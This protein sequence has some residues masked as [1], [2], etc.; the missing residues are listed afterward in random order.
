MDA[1]EAAENPPRS[2]AYERPHV[3]RVSQQR[4]RRVFRRLLENA[5]ETPSKGFAL[6]RGCAV[7]NR[8][9]FSTALM[10]S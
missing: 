10:L 1:A 9:A 8:W 3:A 6:T 4:W 7:Q 5:L 2:R